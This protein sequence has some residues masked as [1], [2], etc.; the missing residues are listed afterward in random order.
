[1]KK[2]IFLAMGFVFVI[3]IAIM[4]NTS[5]SANNGVVSLLSI[6]TMATASAECSSHTQNW[7]CISSSSGQAG[8]VPC[9]SDVVFYCDGK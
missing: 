2:R 7:A 6:R 8:C 4:S 3:A 1:M 9:E 5:H